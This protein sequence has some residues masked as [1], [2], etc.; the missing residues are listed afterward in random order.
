MGN[1]F[2]HKDCIPISYNHLTI[3]TLFLNSL[4]SD[5]QSLSYFTVKSRGEI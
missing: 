5:W 2:Q 4:K 1:H 3:D